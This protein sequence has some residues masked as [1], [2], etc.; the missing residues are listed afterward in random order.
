MEQKGCGRSEAAAGS[1]DH[2]DARDDDARSR[3]HLYEIGVQ[4]FL[5]KLMDRKELVRILFPRCFPAAL[6][7]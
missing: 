3:L 7:S 1:P 2:H 4:P 5:A 6:E